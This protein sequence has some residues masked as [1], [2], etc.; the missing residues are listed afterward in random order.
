[1][2]IL[3]N[4]RWEGLV[5]MKVDSKGQTCFRDS[6][7]ICKSLFFLLYSGLS[8]IVREMWTAYTFVSAPHF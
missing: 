1:M 7:L 4:S 2:Y 6:G 5:N 3:S 8:L